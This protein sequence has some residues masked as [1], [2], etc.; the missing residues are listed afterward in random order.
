M[1]FFFSSSSI[2]PLLISFILGYLQF[3]YLKR[4]LVKL[5]MKFYRKIDNLLP[6]SITERRDYIKVSAV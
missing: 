4:R 6:K 5:P 1:S 2:I 3:M